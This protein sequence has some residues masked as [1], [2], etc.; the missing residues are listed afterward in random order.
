M[1]KFNAM[2]ASKR[3]GRN[4]YVPRLQITSSHIVFCRLVYEAQESFST[5]VTFNT[6][7]SRAYFVRFEDA[8]Y[9]VGSALAY[10]TCVPFGDLI[11]QAKN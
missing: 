7:C 6:V 8:F 1:P 9:F 11:G 4:Y 2:D 10:F 3:V 5:V